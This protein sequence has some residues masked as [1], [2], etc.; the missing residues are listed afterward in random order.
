MTP[1]HGDCLAILRTLPEC[2]VDAVVTD[3]PAGISFMGRSW[4][5]A[6]GGRDLW[7]AWLAERLA[8]CLRVL[9]PGGHAVVW[10]LPRTSG[11]THRA[12]EDAGFEVRDCIT[13]LFGSGF[14]KSLNVGD[15][16]G[17]ALKP[18][19]EFWYLAR[20]PLDGTVA[21]TVTRWGTGVLNIE[22]CRVATDELKPY[23]PGLHRDSPASYNDDAWQ[24]R[25]QLKQP[26]RGRW[27]ANVA[28]TH[29][30]CD[31]G[32]VDGCPIAELDQYG[33]SGGASRFFSTFKYQAKPSPREKNTGLDERNAHPTVKPVE[34]MRWLIRLI[35]PPGGTVLDP[36][37]GSGTTLVAAT[38]EGFDTIGI[39]ERAEYLPII[40]GRVRWAD[41]KCEQLAG[42]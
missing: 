42:R 11:W 29:P 12:L 35:T 7:V 19:A 33:D 3:P 40:E 13:H 15:G 4:D 30:D 17:T 1:L 41:S 31:H 8:E 25:E 10:A 32:C 2:S 39:E 14:P 26:P 38:L 21:S 27:P 6:R 23:R 18:A 36:F 34:L 9:K 16:R 28:L 22:T 20:K 24:G 5:S 37:A